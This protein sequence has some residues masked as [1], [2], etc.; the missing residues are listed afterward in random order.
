MTAA[1][2]RYNISFPTASAAIKAMVELNILEEV[3]G[4]KRNRLYCASELVDILSG[5]GK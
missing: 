5:P 4:L 1:N 2:E 3:T